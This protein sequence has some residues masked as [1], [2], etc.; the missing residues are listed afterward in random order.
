[1]RNFSVS[2]IPPANDSQESSDVKADFCLED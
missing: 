2:E 1:M